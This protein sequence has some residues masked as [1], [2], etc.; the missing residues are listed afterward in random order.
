EPDWLRPTRAFCAGR[1]DVRRASR[2]EATFNLALRSPR[3]TRPEFGWLW[4][5]WHDA[6]SQVC[7]VGALLGRC[8]L[9]Q[10]PHD[11]DRYSLFLRSGHS[12]P[13][14]HDSEVLYRESAPG[15]KH[16]RVRPAEPNIPRLI[17]LQICFP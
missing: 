7:Q 12:V 16:K 17:E 9:G 1:L 3:A 8:C 2:P 5:A 4:H 13:P 6:R 11:P 14:D 10:R 15:R